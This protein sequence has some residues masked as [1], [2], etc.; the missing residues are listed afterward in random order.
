MST[1]SWWQTQ[2][3][4]KNTRTIMFIVSMFDILLIAHINCSKTFE[5]GNQ[6]HFNT[7]NG[8]NKTDVQFTYLVPTDQAWEDLKSGDF[9]SAY[10]VIFW[11]MVAWNH[12][13]NCIKLHFRFCSWV[14]STIK[15]ITFW[16]DIWKLGRKCHWSR[17][18]LILKME[19]TL[20]CCAD[21]L[22]KFSR[23]RRMEVFN[24]NK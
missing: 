18:W 4:G 14:T 20:M 21:H 23:K 24:P 3:W 1:T 8:F 11:K 13:F 17:C 19:K 15:H 2:W 9:A 16:K 6:E 22:S 12:T 7:N 5:L 10:K